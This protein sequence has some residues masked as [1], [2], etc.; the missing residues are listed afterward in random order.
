MSTTPV[1]SRGTVVEPPGA[2]ASAPGPVVRRARV[3][4]TRIDPWSVM[5]LG[6]L[7]S[8]ALG[9][10]LLVATAMVWWVL[11]SAEVFSTISTQIL[12]VTGDG[13]SFRL[14]E[15]LG[16]GRVMRFAATVALIDIVLVTALATLTAF[17][18]NLATSMA[19]PVQVTLT[20]SP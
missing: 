3:G 9:V 8:L 1:E 5:K 7:L 20:E 12:D 13:T 17:L 6:F 15:W 2:P 4:V 16:F 10:V 18:F 11:D 19:G 14:E